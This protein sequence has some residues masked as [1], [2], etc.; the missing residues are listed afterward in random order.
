M[1]TKNIILIASVLTVL[2]LL[3]GTI[4]GVLTLANIQSLHATYKTRI[5]Y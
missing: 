1:N 4:F 5:G 3:T 2:G